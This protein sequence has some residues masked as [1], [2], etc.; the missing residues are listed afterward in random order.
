MNCANCTCGSFVVINLN[1]NPVKSQR[2]F[3]NGKSAHNLETQNSAE[4]L[5][6]GVDF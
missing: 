2:E 4:F 5:K 1:L 6:S 3:Q